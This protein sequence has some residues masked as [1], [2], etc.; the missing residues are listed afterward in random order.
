[1]VYSF[2]KLGQQAR[3]PFALGQKWMLMCARTQNG[4]LRQHKQHAR[5]T[6]NVR[7]GTLRSSSAVALWSYSRMRHR[8]M[9]SWKSADHLSGFV[10]LGGGVLGDAIMNSAC[11]MNTRSVCVRSVR[12]VRLRRK[13]HPHG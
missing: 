10:S 9:K 12:R 3:Q 5:Y 4:R 1:M 2:H 11:A 8:A 7:G 13:L 6:Y